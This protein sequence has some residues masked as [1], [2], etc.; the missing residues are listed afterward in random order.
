MVSIF[1]H[2]KAG[3]ANCSLL[4]QELGKDLMRIQFGETPE[5]ISADIEKDDL[6]A[7]T[8]DKLKKEIAGCL[9]EDFFEAEAYRYLIE[10]LKDDNFTF[11]DLTKLADEFLV[12]TKLRSGYKFFSKEV[13]K[14]L[15]D[16]IEAYFIEGYFYDE[17]VDKEEKLNILTNT[18]TNFNQIDRVE[19]DETLLKD[20]EISKEKFQE[21]FDSKPI[22]ESLDKLCKALSN[23]DTGRFA[24]ADTL[25]YD[26]TL[27]DERSKGSIE[28]KY[29]AFENTK[30]A[31]LLYF[32]KGV[33]D[34]IVVLVIVQVLMEKNHDVKSRVLNRLTKYEQHAK[35]AYLPA[36][37]YLKFFVDRNANHNIVLLVYIARALCLSKVEAKDLSQELGL[38]HKGRLLER[39]DDF[40]EA[41]SP[42]Y[43]YIK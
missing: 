29:C 23:V 33:L 17:I 20:L 32:T 11:D 6:D 1:S 35:Q 40:Y 39:F 42:N 5:Y 34:A 8:I 14:L 3:E 15:K 43:K 9:V 37:K 2:E 36:I 18:S 12:A 13:S 38:N 19:L 26:F 16:V 41:I 7:R 27:L 31:S 25:F 21:V 28:I 4:D 30:E 22:Q 24:I 10:V